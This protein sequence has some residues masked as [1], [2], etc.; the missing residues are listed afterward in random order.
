MRLNGKVAVVTGGARGIGRA[1]VERFVEEGARVLMADILEIDEL[2]AR[3][4]DPGGER[5]YFRRTDVRS[6]GE[7]RAMI[8]ACVAAF[9]DVHLVV[10]NAWAFHSTRKRVTDVTPEDWEDGV[11]VGLAAT[12]W[13]TK[14]AVPHLRKHRSGSIISIASVRGVQAADG[15]LPYE[16]V[17]GGLIHLVKALAVELGPENI[18]VNAIS[19]GMVLTERV[20]AEYPE[21]RRAIALHAYPLGRAAEPREIADAALFLASEESSFITGHNLVVDGGL[22]VQLAEGPTERA[23][24]YVTSTTRSAPS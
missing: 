24:E 3:E 22:T 16:P 23:V 6:E 13:S 19:P 14:H 21:E 17:K 11:A 10:N 9:G 15:W 18:R 5:I 8:E 7:N 20:R 12:L 2:T 4:I 1:I